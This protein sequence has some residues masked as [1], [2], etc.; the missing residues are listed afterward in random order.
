M[1]YRAFDKQIA[2]HNSDARFRGAF[3]GKRGGKTECGAIEGIRH[4]EGKIGWTPNEVDPPLGIIAAPTHD[5]LRRLSMKKFLSYAKPFKPKFNKTN[6]EVLWPNGHEIVGI[7]ADKPE[8]AEGMK[9]QWA[10]IDEIFQVKEQFFLEIQAR[11]ADSQGRIWCTGSL[12]TQY[13]N[14]KQHWAYKYF[15]EAPDPDFAVF[16]WTTADNPFFP[17][18]EILRLKR[19]LDARTYNQMFTI[20]WDVPGTALV[21]DEFSQANV[22]RGYIW[23]RELPTYV[24]I[25][26]GWAHNMAVL[27]FQYDHAKDIVYVF[28][29]IVSPKLTLE[30]L[31]GMIMAKIPTWGKGA[32][33]NDWY[34][35]IAG[36]QEREQ[37]GISNVTWFK[38]NRGIDITYS[39]SL[40]NH[41]ITLVRRYVKDGSGRIGLYVDEVRCPKTLDCIKNYSYPQR[42]GII[43][44]EN[45]VKKDDDPADALRY[46]FV[47]RLDWLADNSPTFKEL[48]R[49]DLRRK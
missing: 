22:M 31:H 27:F 29:E 43:L 49:F 38:K 5:M 11:V 30:V 20:D 33:I 3:A 39:R 17:R 47:N 42:N 13:Q 44:N 40:V 28:D 37:T 41:G 46:F 8:R 45:P 26:W 19:K 2:F 32:R 6:M 1:I 7:S 15:K 24:S 21:Y 10:W 34:C 12:G 18:A 16:E 4:A 35:D 14:P 23:R 25:D 36:D 9:A 48:N